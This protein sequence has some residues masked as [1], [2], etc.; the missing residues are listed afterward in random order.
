MFVANVLALVFLL[1]S[2]DSFYF[3]AFTVADRKLSNLANLW[4]CK[5]IM[6]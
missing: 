4:S 6:A 5:L 3:I 2:S 1:N